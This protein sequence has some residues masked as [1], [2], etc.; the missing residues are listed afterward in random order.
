MSGQRLV[1]SPEHLRSIAKHPLWQS[2]L[3]L[4][5]SANA[6]R[7]LLTAAVPSDQIGP[8]ERLRQQRNVLLH[9]GAT[10]YEALDGIKNLEPVFATL[11]AVQEHLLPLSADAD[12]QH[13]QQNILRPI[14]NSVVFHFETRPF[15]LSFAEAADNEVV[16]AVAGGVSADL[17][18]QLA[19][20]VLTATAF[21]HGDYKDPMTNHLRFLNDAIVYSGYYCRAVDA[22]LLVVAESLGISRTDG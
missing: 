4:A 6:L 17:Y 14:R 22:V 20:D 7:G 5:R 13:F 2:A 12:W 8:V 21:V 11:P 10:L 19:D 3:R 18:Y 1:C 16:F 9:L 15:P